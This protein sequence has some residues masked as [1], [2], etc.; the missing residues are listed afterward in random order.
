[1]P[2]TN[3]PPAET[4]DREFVISRVFDAP[5]ELV[6]LAWTDPQHLAQWWGPKDF[7]N[8]VCELDARP[9]GACRIVMRSPQ[10][11]DY[12]LKGFFL[13]IIPP[14]RLV[15]LMDCSDHPVEW[16]DAVN[17]AR[18]KTKPPF[19]EV[20]QTVTFEKQGDQTKL[21]LRSRMASAAICA[22]MKKIGLT[23]GWSS[24]LDR[25]A[26]ELAQNQPSL[27]EQ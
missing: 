11:V 22:N 10:G 19:L 7:T 23:E 18:D 25:L 26:A 1:M 6:F 8:P 4:A 15:L 3:N 9:G 20:L 5:P 13:Q 16:H 21:T 2:K 14:E 24:S 17:P 27:I 12:A